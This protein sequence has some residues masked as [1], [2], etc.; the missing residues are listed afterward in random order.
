M[1]AT[2]PTSGQSETTPTLRQLPTV[3][4]GWIERRA[5]GKQRFPVLRWRLPG[6]QGKGSY[7]LG[8]GYRDRI[9]A[10]H[11]GRGLSQLFE[12]VTP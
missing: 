4:S 8:R 6:G 5:V 7:Y 11:R 12:D 1:P 9:T 3:Q 10:A 2:L